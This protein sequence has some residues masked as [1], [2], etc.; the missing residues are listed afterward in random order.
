MEFVRGITPEAGKKFV[1]WC[2]RGVRFAG[3]FS[4]D[5]TFRETYPA[6]AP[7]AT[8]TLVGLGELF[9][10]RLCLHC[11]RWFGQSINHNPRVRPSKY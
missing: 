9:F 7:A 3:P 11:Y 10:G 4:S 8:I 1:W 5:Q 2:L 6:G